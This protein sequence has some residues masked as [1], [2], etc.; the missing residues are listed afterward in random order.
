LKRAEIRGSFN[1]KA[2]ERLH[3]DG[4]SSVGGTIH[5]ETIHSSDKEEAF[6]VKVVHKD[7]VTILKPWW[8]TQ[9]E[10]RDIGRAIKG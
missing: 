3:G 5:A 4:K 2:W 10:L 7:S 1:L 6:Q 8:P 9:P